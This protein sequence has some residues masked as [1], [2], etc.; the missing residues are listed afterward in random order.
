MLQS[1]HSHRR[2]IATFAL[3]VA[4]AFALLLALPGN[5]PASAQTRSGHDFTYYSDNTYTT[6]VG[7]RYWCIGYNG[8]WG[9][10]TPYAV[11]GDFP[12]N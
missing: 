11:I 1:L 10:T 3:M 7:Y 5:A 2:P 4:L 9:T 8:G 6:V 12:C